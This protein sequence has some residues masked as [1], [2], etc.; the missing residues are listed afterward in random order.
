MGLA[1]VL[2]E[3]D[4]ALVMGLCERITVLDFGV[5]IAEGT[6]GEVQANEAVIHAYLG[7]GSAHA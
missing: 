6:P 1:L 7:K 3:H 2:I 4:M 5:V